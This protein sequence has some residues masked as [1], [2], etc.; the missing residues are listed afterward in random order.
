MSPTKLTQKRR[1]V[2]PPARQPAIA[3]RH[4]RIQ[5]HVVVD[6]P[7]HGAGTALGERIQIRLQDRSGGSYGQPAAL[8][9]PAVGNQPVS[10]VLGVPRAVDEMDPRTLHALAF[11]QAAQRPVGRA[12]PAVLEDKDVE[13]RESGVLREAAKVNEQAVHVFQPLCIRDHADDQM[14]RRTG[15]RGPGRSGRGDGPAGRGTGLRFRPSEIP[16]CPVPELLPL[17]LRHAAAVLAAEAVQ[18]LP[19]GGRPGRRQARPRRAG[20]MIDGRLGDDAVAHARQLGDAD[21]QVAVRAT[22]E[23]L[24]E[25]PGFEQHAQADDRIAALNAGIAHQEI[26]RIEVPRRSRQA[27]RGALFDSPERRRDHV[28]AAGLG[29]FQARL[30][31]APAPQVIVVENRD[32]EPVGIATRPKQVIDAGVP[33]A[34]R[35]FRPPVT[36]E[37]D[38]D[39]QRSPTPDRALGS[40][41]L[42]AGRI[43][44]DDHTVRRPGLFRDR[45]KGPTRQQSRSICRGD[46]NRHG[47]LLD[48]RNGC[49]PD[50]GLLESRRQDRQNSGSMPNPRGSP[51]PGSSGALLGR[52]F[53]RC[54]GNVGVASAAVKP[55]PLRR[56]APGHRVRGWASL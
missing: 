18:P 52:P 2:R 51:H 54:A 10:R 13:T 26:R 55:C 22:R 20:E 12:A 48:V 46:E 41:G 49:L 47:R 56:P 21:V 24:V 39:P 4:Q 19:L 7:D 9:R 32:V 3:R 42:V 40:F 27:R 17:V 34:G 25:Q 45:R 23:R 36:Q 14:R 31:V 1:D 37:F 8:S 53:G 5:P 35:A 16:V 43:V 38:V 6:D 44:D 11:D 50:A 33:C 15:G 28:E 30:K 29:R